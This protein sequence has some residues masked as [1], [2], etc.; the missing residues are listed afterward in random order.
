M[1]T[2]CAPVNVFCAP[3]SSKNVNVWFIHAASPVGL[4]RPPP[5]AIHFFHSRSMFEWWSQKIGSRGDSP[6]AMSPLM[7]LCTL[8]CGDCSMLPLPPPDGKCAGAATDLPP[9]LGEPTIDV[10]K[11]VRLNPL[12]YATSAGGQRRAGVVR[13]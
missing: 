13:R 2:I 5:S 9:K 12:E 10:V 1:L 3:F 11:F 8:L 4:S 6:V 7:S